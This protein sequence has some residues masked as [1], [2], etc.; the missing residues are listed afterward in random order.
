M[1]IENIDQFIKKINETKKESKVDLSAE[2]DLSLAIMNLVSIEEHFFFTA[3]KTNKEKYFK[4]LEETRK[5][6]KE[7][8]KRLIKDYEGEVWC[9][10]KHLLAASM[11]L[12]EVGTKYLSKGEK[13]EAYDFFEKSYNLYT[14][15]WGLVLKAIPLEKVKGLSENQLNIHD[16]EE[17]GVLDKL[18]NLIQKV[19]DCCKE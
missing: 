12:M 8:L 11:R 19:V 3:V 15:F 6:R 16:K 18:K 9:I 17:N 5:M 10:S 13:K 1:A 14:M 7:L 4:L 2:E